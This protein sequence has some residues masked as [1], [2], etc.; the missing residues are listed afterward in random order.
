MEEDLEMM[1]QIKK[2]IENSMRRIKEFAGYKEF[3]DK[4]FNVKDYLYQN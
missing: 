2:A 3:F 4:D 1:E